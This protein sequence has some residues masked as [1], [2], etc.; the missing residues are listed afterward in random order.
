M[1][2]WRKTGAA[3]SGAVQGHDRPVAGHLAELAVTVELVD[4]VLVAR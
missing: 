1:L 4:L 2:G 3:S